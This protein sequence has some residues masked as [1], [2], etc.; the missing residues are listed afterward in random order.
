MDGVPRDF[1]RSVNP[2]KLVNEFTGTINENSAVSAACSLQ[3][4]TDLP[5]VISATTDVVWEASL[6]N[7]VSLLNQQD[8]QSSDAITYTCKRGGT[9]EILANINIVQVTGNTGAVNLVELVLS[10]GR[11]IHQRADNGFRNGVS[12]VAILQ[13][14]ANDTF[15][16]QLLL[17][18][19][20]PAVIETGSS[21]IIK[22]IA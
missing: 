6:F 9:F 14:N 21:V 7:S 5:L 17:P 1:P 18:P 10:S 12:I 16:F 13:L 4:I 19:P 15:K 8:F 2:R 11:V 22:R 3:R 20:N